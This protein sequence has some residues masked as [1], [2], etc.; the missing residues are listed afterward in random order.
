[1][2]TFTDADK[3]G[4]RYEARTVARKCY[5]AKGECLVRVECVFLDTR[6]AVPGRNVATEE[7]VTLCE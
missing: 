5:E 2:F 1:M 3:S 6:D 4:I 7:F